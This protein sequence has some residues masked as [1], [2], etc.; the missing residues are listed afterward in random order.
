MEDLN[1]GLFANRNTKLDYGASPSQL[2]MRLVLKETL[3]IHKQKL[4]RKL[5]H[6]KVYQIIKKQ[7]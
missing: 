3:P 4:N 7:K 5:P 2:P 1:F 6:S